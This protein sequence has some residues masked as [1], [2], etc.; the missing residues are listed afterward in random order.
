MKP[1]PPSPPVPPPPPSA[2]P[3]RGHA[4]PEPMPAAGS[5]AGRKALMSVSSVSRCCGCSCSCCCCCCRHGIPMHGPIIAS[6]PSTPGSG[7][8]ISPATPPPPYVVNGSCTGAAASRAGAAAPVSLPVLAAA[9][10]APPSRDRPK[11]SNFEDYIYY[12]YTHVPCTTAGTCPGEVVPWLVLFME[13]SPHVCMPDC[14][15]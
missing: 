11:P 2:P 13:T 10:S 3:P 12:R 5:A 14:L 6:A 4:A 8:S 15:W 9:A 7:T 1:Q